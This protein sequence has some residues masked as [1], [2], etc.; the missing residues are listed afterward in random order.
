MNSKTLKLSIATC[1][2]LAMLSCGSKSKEEKTQTLETIE[3]SQ[4]EKEDTI[5]H[6]IARAAPPTQPFIIQPLLSFWEDNSI[7]RAINIPVKS[8]SSGTVLYKPTLRARYDFSDLTN[9]DYN[10]IFE[11]YRHGEPN[12]NFMC[13]EPIDINTETFLISDVLSNFDSSKP[14]IIVAMHNEEFTGD[15]GTQNSPTFRALKSDVQ[16][17]VRAGFPFLCDYNESQWVKINSTDNPEFVDQRPRTIGGG[18]IPP[19]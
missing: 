13:Y 2:L 7:T 3:N 6:S 12:Y 15:F 11:L 16:D 14:L 10:I 4:T 19:R 9:R 18:T 17:Y 8:N 1:T 5:S